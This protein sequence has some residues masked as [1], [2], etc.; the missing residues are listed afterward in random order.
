M[1]AHQMRSNAE[2]LVT[3]GHK[4]STVDD[5]PI[6]PLTFLLLLEE[7]DRMDVIDVECVC[8]LRLINKESK[9]YVERILPFVSLQMRSADLLYLPQKYCLTE[10][11]EGI[12]VTTRG[13][14]RI[15]DDTALAL[16]KSHLPKLKKLSIPCSTSVARTIIPCI[17]YWQNLTYLT[18]E[19]DSDPINTFD[20]LSKVRRNRLK[21]FRYSSRATIDD[22]EEEP[23][24]EDLVATIATTLFR[25]QRL[26][27]LDLDL[28]FDYSEEITW[29]I[30]GEETLPN[31]KDLSLTVGEGEDNYGP[32]DFVYAPLWPK[33]K[34]FT[35]NS[36]N[37]NFRIELLSKIHNVNFLKQL[38]FLEIHLDPDVRT[39]FPN[40]LPA[41]GAA[42]SIEDLYLDF[43]D[44]DTFEF[45]GIIFSSLKKLT[46][47]NLL[48]TACYED[49]AL[50]KM[51]ALE[52]LEIFGHENLRPPDDLPSFLVDYNTS[53]FPNLRSLIV[54]DGLE[55][56]FGEL[57]ATNLSSG[58]SLPLWPNLTSVRVVCLIR[59][60][61]V[62]VLKLLP[63]QCPSLKY[64]T[65]TEG[66][67]HEGDD[68]EII[69]RLKDA[70][71]EGFWS[72]LK[73]VVFQPH[74]VMDT[75]YRRGYNSPPIF[76][77]KDITVPFWPIKE[78][79]SM[80]E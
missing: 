28:R 39:A 15:Y 46:L 52:S 67:Y 32:F 14:E 77:G 20:S 53:P 26:T 64:L 70:A 41:L 24:I 63:A 50:A 34:R 16:V 74:R 78:G 48:S 1:P 27:N 5:Q 59:L 13:Y 62:E 33:L 66:R 76:V 4:E 30:F 29:D 6:T 42:G 17:P 10:R 69:N 19:S 58:S 56:L 71:R 36:S 60:I 21:S 72:T 12:H 25:L 45:K 68:V 80:Y 61:D 8:K 51:P 11:I 31:L 18:L 57:L 54:G 47:K 65:I 73:A 43:W 79:D 22:D 49:L 35:L 44:I 7:L 23:D 75:K 9:S 3:G 37:S 55:T 38:A 2:N 40:L